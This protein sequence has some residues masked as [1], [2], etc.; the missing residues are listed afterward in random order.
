MLLVG[1][2]AGD[3]KCADLTTVENVE[4]GNPL[5]QIIAGIVTE[6]LAL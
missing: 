3:S 4:R 6:N 2:G 1:R 5:S